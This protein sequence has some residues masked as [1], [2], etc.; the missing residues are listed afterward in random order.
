MDD[1]SASK[2]R[3][4]A[5]LLLANPDVPT[6]LDTEATGLHVASGDDRCIG[7]SVA[8]VL[9]GVP[10]S[11]YWALEHETGENVD[12]DT[13]FL[14]RD[15]L[16]AHTGLLIYAN[17]QYDI[18]SLETQGINLV[19]HNFI[20][21]CTMAHLI[22][23]NKPMNKGVDSLAKFYLHEEG[24]I[25]DEFVE[26]EKKSGNRTITPEQ[27]Y[28]YA[29]MDA[30]STWRIWN[31][32]RNH[33]EW[34]QLPE[35]I[36]AQKQRLIR[37]LISMRR[38]GVRVDTA[39]A[40]EQAKIGRDRMAAITEELGLNPG[41]PRQLETLLIDELKLPVLKR[42]PGGQVCFDKSVMPIY[43]DMLTKI[44]DHRAALIREYRGWQKAVTA[45]Y[46]PYVKLCDKDGR[47]RSTFHTHRVT[48]GRLSSSEPNLQQISKDGGLAWNRYVKKCFIPK[49]G[50]VLLSADYSQLEL[51][52]AT[53]YA[54]EQALKDIFNADRDIFT[55]MA[56]QLKMKRQDVKTLTY[57]LQYGA[58]VTRLMNVF[59]V[60]KT[61][62]NALKDNYWNTYP[63]F[64]ALND[65]CAGK[66]VSTGKI[67][68]WNGRYRR[69]E[70]S[71]DS[72][73]AMNS[74]IQ[75]GAAD[76]VERIMVRLYDELESEDCRL[77]LAVHDAC[78]FEVVKAKYARYTRK[79]QS[80]MEDI[81]G[82]MP[83]HLKGAFAGVKFAVA[84]E[85]WGS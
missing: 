53:A 29:V 36:W 33:D 76:L 10:Y 62:A 5:N 85:E 43:D 37:V 28:D 6:A 15:A 20:D 1:N 58:G 9:D 42:T 41:S 69:F 50:F 81:D 75:G 12:D 71:S 25:K 73:K 63:R 8:F 59:G 46:E 2:D 30:V 40:M 68:L 66:V 52:L 61:E 26:K 19:D 16:E 23:E 65:A 32:L 45:S 57:S 3:L 48:T 72:Y 54:D 17:A 51:R 70:Y 67:K 27:M 22:N 56:G 7:I 38:H 83:E 4:I 55:E 74:L 39:L 24:K 13:Y 34:I 14:I 44:G 82:V 80:I 31:V 21:I 60:T 64:K 79:V 84:T 77:L 18:L 49:D 78:V 47:V 35:D 11:H